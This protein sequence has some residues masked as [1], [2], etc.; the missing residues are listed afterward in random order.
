M[1]ESPLRLKENIGDDLAILD[2]IIR[3]YGQW[4]RSPQLS[5]GPLVAPYETSKA[6]TAEW[7]TPTRLSY[8]FVAT[9]DPPL[10][11]GDGRRDFEASDSLAV[12]L[13]FTSEFART[14]RDLLRRADL[15]TPEARSEGVTYPLRGVLGNEASRGHENETTWSG[16]IPGP[17]VD[18]GSEPR[19]GAAVEYLAYS[20][21]FHSVDR[22][23]PSNAGTKHIEFRVGES[24]SRQ[25]KRRRPVSPRTGATPRASLH[26]R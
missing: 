8:P 22:S 12:G 7:T 11:A 19:R 21:S 23:A 2:Q 3:P 1:L 6:S 24:A 9:L 15:R 4:G 14:D 18:A 10:D 5:G 13:G 20:A 25:M 26:D 17:A 16:S